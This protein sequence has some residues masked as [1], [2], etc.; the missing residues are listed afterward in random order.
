MRSV[1]GKMVVRDSLR[2]WLS[3][4]WGVDVG[5]GV[6]LVV[7]VVVVLDEIHVSLIALAR[8]SRCSS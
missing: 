8:L 2:W 6:G 1:L 4:N 5:V 3:L 7:V